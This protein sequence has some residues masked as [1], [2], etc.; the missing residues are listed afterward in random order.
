MLITINMQV[1]LSEEVMVIIQMAGMV[2]NNLM[3]MVNYHHVI[4]N[5]TTKQMKNSI[6]S[7]E[8]KQLIEI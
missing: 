2:D 6:I 8:Y 4:K 3:E 5:R 1:M 7:K